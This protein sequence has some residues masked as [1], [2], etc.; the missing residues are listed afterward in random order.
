MSVAWAF[1]PT[2][3]MRFTDLTLEMRVIGSYQPGY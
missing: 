1:A 3:Y 2:Q